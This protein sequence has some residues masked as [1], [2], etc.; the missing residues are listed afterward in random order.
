MEEEVDETVQPENVTGGGGRVATE[1]VYN[2]D[3]DGYTTMLMYPNS[4]AWTQILEDPNYDISEFTYFP[5]V[6]T[7]VGSVAV[8][9]N[10]D[11]ETPDEFITAAQNGEIAVTASGPAE[12]GVVQSVVLGEVSETYSA[13][14]I[15][16]NFV[17]FDS[18]GSQITAIQR[19]DANAMGGSVSS[20]LPY[21]KSGDLRFV[22]TFKTGDRPEL[23]PDTPTVEEAGLDNADQIAKMTG[24]LRVFSGPPDI[25]DGP[26]DRLREIYT[27]AI[28]DEDL[29]AEAEEIDRPITYAD[30]E[31]AQ[32]A[33]MTMYEG[34]RERSDLLESLVG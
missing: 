24:A 10:T 15:T 14:D 13:S 4:V 1:Q 28:Q 26:R 33:I 34:W 30:S 5:Q 9:T 20:L 32:D 25:P 18:R 29:L 16:D 2:E 19:G 12:S 27:S 8:G 22:T 17:Q 11:I 6:A 21:V 3:P 31:T 7:N 23:A